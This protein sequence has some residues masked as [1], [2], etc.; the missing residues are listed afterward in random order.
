MTNESLGDLIRRAEQTGMWLWSRYQNLWFSPDA[1]RRENAAGRFLWDA[2]NF[3]LRH[4]CERRAQL[5]KRAQEAAAD[6]LR[7][8]GK[9]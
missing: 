7:F 6:L 1:L 3:Q 9:I 2:E 8:K 4:P 5:E